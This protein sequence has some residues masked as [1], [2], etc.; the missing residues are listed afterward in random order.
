MRQMDG[1]GER[2]KVIGFKVKE[3]PNVDVLSLGCI[4]T[5]EHIFGSWL[6]RIRVHMEHEKNRDTLENFRAYVS[7]SQGIRFF[8]KRVAKRDLNRFC[9]VVQI[10][11]VYN[12]IC[13]YLNQLVCKQVDIYLLTK[14]QKTT[15]Q[16]LQLNFTF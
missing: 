9:S 8:C 13:I 5:T 6:L 12:H 4:E 10:T 7:G 2:G 16:F 15:Q 3:N 14:K 1:Q 11:P